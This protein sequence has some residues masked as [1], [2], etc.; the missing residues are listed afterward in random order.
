MTDRLT[1]ANALAA[2]A[3]TGK[4]FTLLFRHGTLEVEIYKPNKIDRQ[5]PH[6]RDEVYVVLSGSGTFVSGGTRRPFEAGELL[7]APAGVEHRFEGFTDDFATWRSEEHTS[8][9][10]SLRHL[11][12]RLL[13][14]KK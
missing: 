6:T 7:F 1:P 10:Q 13:L 5:Q 3:K 2:L 8:E 9:L 12:C 4:E 14:E 11:V